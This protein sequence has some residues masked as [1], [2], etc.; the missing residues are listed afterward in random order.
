MFESLTSSFRSAAALLIRLAI[1]GFGILT[2]LPGLLFM[3]RSHRLTRIPSAYPV[4]PNE[5][6]A[7]FKVA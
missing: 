3:A 4:D 6:T 2:G 7:H 5:S 1:V